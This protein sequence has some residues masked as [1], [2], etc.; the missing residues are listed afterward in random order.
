MRDEEVDVFH[1]TFH[2]ERTLTAKQ[3]HHSTNKLALFDPHTKLR[4]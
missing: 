1:I 2:I 4:G 3:H